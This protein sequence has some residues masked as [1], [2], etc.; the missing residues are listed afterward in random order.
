[1]SGQPSYCQATFCART[2][3]GQFM[4]AAHW[5]HLDSDQKARLPAIDHR[6][7]LYLP[8]TES[9][10][11]QLEVLAQAVETVDRRAG[12]PNPPINPYRLRIQPFEAPPAAP[13]QGRLLEDDP[14]YAGPYGPGRDR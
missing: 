7:I 3:D 1:V 5:S 14:S 11:A 13:M 9:R 12:I 8:L 6:T 2:T 10:L 4:C